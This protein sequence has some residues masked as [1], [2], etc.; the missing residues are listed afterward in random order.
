MNDGQIDGARH[1]VTALC[2]CAWPPT[3]L[4]INEVGSEAS[5]GERVM[6]GLGGSHAVRRRAVAVP[7]AGAAQAHARQPF[8]RAR[9][10]DEVPGAV[11][12]RWTGR[13]S[14]SLLE[15]ASPFG[16]QHSTQPALWAF[17]EL[18]GGCCVSTA[19][20]EACVPWV[21]ISSSLW[22][23]RSRTRCFPIGHLRRSRDFFSSLAGR[24]QAICPL[25]FRRGHT[26]PY[27]A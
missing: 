16:A 12:T 10:A 7:D 4:R 22:A 11:P 2:R 5:S 18:R 19:W 21:A 25:P 26:L 13:L 20:V 14:A 24:G 17:S 15:E 8:G 6:S 27:D 23:V 1:V 3:G 9:H